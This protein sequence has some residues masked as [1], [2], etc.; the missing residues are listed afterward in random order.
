MITSLKKNLDRTK[1]HELRKNSFLLSEL[2]K[3][4]LQ[5]QHKDEH[6]EDNNE[7]M[8]TSHT[9]GEHIEGEKL[10]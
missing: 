8:F 2:L 6:E 5:V 7:H 3:S 1:P 9:V 4:L 10:I